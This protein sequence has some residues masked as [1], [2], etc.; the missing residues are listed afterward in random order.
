M[1]SSVLIVGEG[2]FPL[3][4]IQRARGLATLALQTVATPQEAKD[5][6][7]TDAAELL[8][9][10]A[11][12][13]ESWELCR[14]LKQPRS[15]SSVY[16]ILV[17]DRTYPS[18]YQEG[19]LLLRYTS[20]M[21]TALEFGADAYV[22]LMESTAAAEAAPQAAVDSEINFVE[23]Q[24]RLFQAQLRLGLRHIQSFRE[25]SRAND[26]L[27][28]IALSDSLT[29]LGNRRAFDWELPR[30]IQTAREQDIP[31]SLLILDVDHFKVVN[32]RYGHLTGDQVL[33]MVAERLSHNMRFYETPFRYGGEEFVVIL[34]STPPEGARVIGDRLCRLI[35]DKP[36]VIGEGLSLSITVSVGV[37]CLLEDDDERGISLLDR[38]DQNLLKAKASGRNQVVQG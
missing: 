7:Q 27:S 28:S 16:C 34:N 13:P 19:A 11:S 15:S 26:L 5:L 33:Q 18:D 14:S 38:A 3:Q 10:Q 17:D 31:L 20:L 9:L 30:Q 21:T 1:N 37:S 32:D 29:Q 36:F 4:V 25:L 12:Q 22:W 23:H 2:D 35:G 24:N 6:L 8:I